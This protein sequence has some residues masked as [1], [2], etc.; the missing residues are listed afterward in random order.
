[1]DDAVIEARYNTSHLHISCIGL[2]ELV[3]KVAK[4]LSQILKRVLLCS[5][6]INLVV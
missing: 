1:M 2:E 3:A 5:G 4:V 6:T